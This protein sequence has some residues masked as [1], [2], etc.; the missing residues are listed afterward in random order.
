ML[1]ALQGG[2]EL[3]VHGPFGRSPVQCFIKVSK[4]TN[5][6]PHWGLSRGP[7]WLWQLEGS[8]A[9]HVPRVS[10]PTL[11]LKHSCGMSLTMRNEDG[12]LTH[13]INNAFI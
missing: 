2:R 7:T 5:V 4:I 6:R 9:G 8:P 13:I 11:P 12:V 3:P 1:G 10:L